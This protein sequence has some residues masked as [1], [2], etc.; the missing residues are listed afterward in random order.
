M[1][2]CVFAIVASE[3]KMWLWLEWVDALDYV[4][5]LRMVNPRG[6]FEWGDGYV[7]G[8]ETV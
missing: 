5:D 8:L 1:R 7:W 4:V 3:A 6:M 2:L